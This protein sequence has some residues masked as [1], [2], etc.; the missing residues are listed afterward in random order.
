MTTRTPARRLLR[1]RPDEGQAA[2]LLVLSVVVLMSIAV[3]LIAVMGRGV[4][5]ETEA[6]TAGDA[7]ALAAAQGYVDQVDAHLT[8]L[9][10]TPGLAIG[11]L[12][13]LLDQP[14]SAWTGTARSEARRLAAA[15]GST[16]TAFAVES[17]LTSMRFSTRAR[18]DVPT[19]EGGSKR[20][21]F[22]ATAEAR[23]TG[24]PLCFDRSRLGLW[25][26]GRCLVGDK[27]ILVPPSAEPDPP[28]EE[29]GPT[30]PPAPPP[31]PDDPVE[32]GG[33]DLAHLLDQLRRPVEWQVTLVE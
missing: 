1:E 12:R 5:V 6:R 10:T 15:N 2:L 31:G 11:H 32:I 21:H 25:W 16:L 22:A 26:H 4:T 17:R 7:A 23:I 24:G 8:A 30:E 20:P 9:P 33:D 14:Q 27:L 19:V 28:E 18:A 29:D 3:T 13:Q